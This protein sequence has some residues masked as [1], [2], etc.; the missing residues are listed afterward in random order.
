MFPTN[1][2]RLGKQI[3]KSLRIRVEP[4]MVR[5]RRTKRVSAVIYGFSVLFLAGCTPLYIWDTH[6][7][8]TPR[9]KSIG[10]AELIREPVATLGLITP[11]GLQGFSPFLSRALIAAMSEASPSIRG[12]PAHETVNMIN[13]QGFISGVR[14]VNLGLCS[15]RDSGT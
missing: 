4:R 9:S 5:L 15:K 7:T 14:R 10:V 1:A 11:A 3:A 13:G 8:S 2:L 6:I 12:I